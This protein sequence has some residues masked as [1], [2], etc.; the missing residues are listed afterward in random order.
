MG[1]A[2]PHWPAVEGMMD[3]CIKLEFHIIANHSAIN[4]HLINNY[5]GIKAQ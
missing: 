5:M 4:F 3:A 2:N 1:M